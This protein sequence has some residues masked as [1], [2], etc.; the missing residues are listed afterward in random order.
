MGTEV[1]VPMINM[2]GVLVL[3]MVV[4]PKMLQLEHATDRQAKDY[5][6]QADRRR[7]AEAAQTRVDNVVNLKA[8]RKPAPRQANASGTEP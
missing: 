2:S 4:F 8:R 3:I 5:R 1:Y 7:L 6:R